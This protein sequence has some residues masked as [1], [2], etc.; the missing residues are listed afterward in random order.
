M[1][2]RYC[3]RCE[4]EV[5]FLNENEYEAIV[6]IYVKCM[7]L[8][9]DYREKHHA[10]LDETPIDTMFEPVSVAYERITGYRG[11]HHDEVRHHRLSM[12]G[13]DCPGCGK[14]LRTANAK[15]CTA[16]GW[17]KKV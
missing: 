3:W 4:S 10:A 13:A 2:N 6:D 11:M 5:P 15:L 7:G 8:V 17:T 12:L 14:P 9:K 1:E 16:C